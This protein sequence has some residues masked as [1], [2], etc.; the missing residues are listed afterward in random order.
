MKKIGCIGHDCSACAAREKLINKLK[1]DVDRWKSRAITYK[2]QADKLRK[3]K[4]APV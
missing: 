4:G 1:K 3:G 2:N